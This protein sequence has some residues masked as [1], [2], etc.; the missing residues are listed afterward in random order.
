MVPPRVVLVV[1]SKQRRSFSQQHP[2]SRERCARSRLRGCCCATFTV[3][4]FHLPSNA[5]SSILNATREQAKRT[6]TNAVRKPYDKLPRTSNPAAPD[7]HPASIFSSIGTGSTQGAGT[8]PTGVFPPAQGASSVHFSTFA[9]A[10]PTVGNPT[11]GAA[12]SGA[13]DLFGKNIKRQRPLTPEFGDPMAKKAKARGSDIDFSS[14][15]SSPELGSGGPPAADAFVAQEAGVLPSRPRASSSH[16]AAAATQ[17]GLSQ[18]AAAADVGHVSGAHIQHGSVPVSAGAPVGA[19]VSVSAGGPIF[20][21]H[22]TSSTTDASC[23]SSGSDGFQPLRRQDSANM[24]FDQELDGEGKQRQQG[25]ANPSLDQELDGDRSRL[26]RQ[27]SANMSFDQELVDGDRNKLRRQ[28]SANMSF[29]QELDGDDHNKLPRQDSANMSFDAGSQAV[30]GDEGSQ[31]EQSQS[32]SQAYQ[33]QSTGDGSSEREGRKSYHTVR[34]HATGASSSAA[35]AGSSNERSKDR[36]DSGV[37]RPAPQTERRL[38][39]FKIKELK[40]ILAARGVE[41]PPGRVVAS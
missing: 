14:C 17:P 24:S 28:D 3:R 12:S 35:S 10:T 33:E 19:P 31:R 16:P 22:N 25:S 41:I 29:D 18:A 27:D 37:S 40:D 6:L 26:R 21:P 11:V 1:C 30:D 8:A 23:S 32:A 36:R 20:P 7:E 4:V 5:T 34:S 2:R 39:S 9:F 15:Q 38:E 13:V